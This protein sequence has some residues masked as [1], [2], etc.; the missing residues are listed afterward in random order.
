M[1]EA[2]SQVPPQEDV[3]FRQWDW[4]LN[5]EHMDYFLNFRTMM[6]K[7]GDG[8]TMRRVAGFDTPDELVDGMRTAVCPNVTNETAEEDP[9][10]DCCSWCEQALA[11]SDVHRCAECRMPVCGGCAR[12][13]FVRDCCS[14]CIHGYEVMQNKQRQRGKVPGRMPNTMGKCPEE[15]EAATFGASGPRDCDAELVSRTRLASASS[16]E[17]ATYVQEPPET[18]EDPASVRWMGRWLVPGGQ[19]DPPRVCQRCEE[20]DALAQF[21]C[22]RCHRWVCSQCITAIMLCGDCYFSPHPVRTSRG[23]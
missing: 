4:P 3:T 2:L 20:P 8:K 13:G 18:P 14:A 21:Q 1:N 11:R 12:Q 6:L 10:E 23:Y 16:P 22:T 9:V 5:P 15:E 19:L 17:I 7:S